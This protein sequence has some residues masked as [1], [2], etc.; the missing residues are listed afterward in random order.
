LG[1]FFSEFPVPEDKPVIDS[2]LSA[3]N[4]KLIPNLLLFVDSLRRAGVSIS[5][6]QTIDLTQAL[7]LVDIGDRAQ[8]FHAMRSLLINRKQD[9][10]LFE[11]MFNLFWRAPAQDGRSK[12]QKTPLAPRHDPAKWKPLN[13]ATLMAERARASAPELEVADKSGSFSA[14]EILQRKEFSAMTPE[15][16]DAVKRLIQSMRWRV[17]QRRTRR[18]TPHRSGRQLNLRRVMR[19]CARHGG[20]PLELAWKTRKIKPRPIVVLADISG[21]MEKYSR[22]L[23]QFCYSM[24]RGLNNVETFVFGT[25]LSRITPELRIKNIDRAIGQATKVVVDWA[26]GTRIGESLRT[27]NRNWSRRVMRRGAVVL[28]ISDGW[29]RGDVS[30]LRREMRFLQHRCYRLIWLNPLLGKDNYQ[31]LVEG[32]AAALPFV[33]DFLPSHNLQSLEALG[34]HLAALR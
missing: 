26:G 30:T 34:E 16:L 31:P 23:V 11:Q 4:S 9:L 33:D 28:V 29:E 3:Q 20:V 19:N 32:M 21:S 14:T 8:V 7:E 1:Q 24:T 2:T 12:A 15:E 18:F 17:S 10:L 13:I 27:F 6:T 5:L 22:L 25:R